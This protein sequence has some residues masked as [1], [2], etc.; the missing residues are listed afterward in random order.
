[1]HHTET[2]L[3]STF[4]RTGTPA[5]R[6]QSRERERRRKK[7]D[8]VRAL[9]NRDLRS[10]SR[11]RLSSGMSSSGGR[12]DEENR[13]VLRQ[14]SDDDFDN[15]ARSVSRSRR[16]QGDLNT[17]RRIGCLG[18][19][20][21]RTFRPKGASLLTPPTVICAT[22]DDLNGR[23]QSSRGR[24]QSTS[25]MDSD[26]VRSKSRGTNNNRA[27]S[28][29]KSVTRERSGRDPSQ[30]RA[31]SKSRGVDD[32]S[33][34]RSKSRGPDSTDMERSQSRGSMKRSQSQGRS[35]DAHL[36]RPRSQSRGRTDEQTFASSKKSSRSKSRDRR[37]DEG[38]VKSS[39]SSRS[40]S[41]DRRGETSK[42][43]R[44][45][46]RGRDGSTVAT[47]KSSKSASAQRSSATVAS[48]SSG[49]K[50]FADHTGFSNL[51]HYSGS[52]G[53][54]SGG[55]EETS[56]L[57]YYKDDPQD[58]LREQSAK[59]ER[60]S[61]KSSPA[62]PP[63]LSETVV[64]KS[65]T[66]NPDSESIVTN[67]YDR[68]GHCVRHPHVRLRKKKLWGGGWNILIANCPDCCLEEMGRL[69][70]IQKEKEKAAAT[71]SPEVE[72]KKEKKRGDGRSNDRRSSQSVYPSSSQDFH[73][74]RSVRSSKSSR[75]F[76]DTAPQSQSFD[77]NQCAP[78]FEFDIPLEEQPGHHPESFTA[79]KSVRSR[80]KSIKSSKSA[81]S[82]KSCKTSKS[83][84]SHGTGKSGKSTR[85]SKTAKSGKSTK[86][87]NSS[88]STRANNPKEE[89]SNRRPSALSHPSPTPAAA[90]VANMPFTDHF[91]CSGKYSGEVN[92]FGQPHG[93]G[94]L[95]YDDGGTNEGIWVNGHRDDDER[96]CG[97]SVSNRS[98]AK[99]VSNRSVSNKSVSG[100]SVSGRSRAS[101][102]PGRISEQAPHNQQ[103]HP[104]HQVQQRGYV[105]KLPWSDVNG[106]GGHY[107]GEVNGN[108][109]PEGK[110]YM[111]YSNGVVEEGMWCNGVFQPP[112][113]F[114]PP[115]Y[116]QDRNVPSS[117]MS[118]WSLRS[119][120]NMGN[121]NY[122]HSGGGRAGSVYGTRY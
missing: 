99:S 61:R 51:T 31:R 64:H 55:T 90:R 109:A 43:S 28:R 57:S 95:R 60:K 74:A 11:D 70:K 92:S 13:L 22:S 46:S 80:A 83:A 26:D 117:S 97:R 27:T 65:T 36:S 115:P 91:G 24:R 105:T 111:E 110:G 93:K 87:S 29:G 118:V 40:K 49:W 81:K 88:R 4:Q 76:T 73:E 47:S 52:S 104:Y 44:S 58:D 69:V 38:T 122:D 79:A 106:F 67:L 41:R 84:K 45:Q 19:S 32:K 12:G 50:K 120:P 23:G 116:H 21:D 98:M 108:N 103:P 9:S 77:N 2:T 17:R 107:T 1:M 20:T 66:Y 5:E 48:S 85:T 15:R 56:P 75:R 68:T 16:T 33:R 96:D 18:A 53:K 8:E 113:N 94:V 35:I 89:P 82:S 119:T 63:A 71:A 121:N 59:K 114:E 102:S 25:S 62:M 72:H 112:L 39:K 6:F 42:T 10:K 14:N 37:K 54:F 100:R 86:T 7:R 78:I 34:A 3:K 101:Q 30:S